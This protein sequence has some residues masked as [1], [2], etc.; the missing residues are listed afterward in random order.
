MVTRDDLELLDR[1]TVDEAHTD[2]RFEPDA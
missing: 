2:G 1:A